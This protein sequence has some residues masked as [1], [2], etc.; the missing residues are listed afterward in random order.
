MN[1]LVV[2]MAPLTLLR[3]QEGVYA[4]QFRELGLT[5]YG[6]AETE[7]TLALKRLFNRFIHYYRDAGRIEER[8]DELGATWYW[9]DEYPEGLPPFEDTNGLSAPEE[10]RPALG[11][12]S[13][14]ERPASLA[15]AA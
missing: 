10:I 8:L 3:S 7:A 6:S 9:A 12:E 2:V 5:G 13:I 4:A 11:W 14:P 1:R 15:A